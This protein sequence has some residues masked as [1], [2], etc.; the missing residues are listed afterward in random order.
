MQGR[1][2]WILAMGGKGEN[3][4]KSLELKT[5]DHVAASSGEINSLTTI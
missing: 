5:I 1:I 2:P 3:S 4:Y